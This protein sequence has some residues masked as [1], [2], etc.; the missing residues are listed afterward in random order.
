[1]WISHET[2]AQAN[3]FGS[4][5]RGAQAQE[6]ANKFCSEI[7]KLLYTGIH[8]SSP[9]SSTRMWKNTTTIQTISDHSFNNDLAA[10]TNLG[11]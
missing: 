5:A 3:H 11:S 2:Y 6:V 4:L 9:H 7:H 10:A 8:I 1:M